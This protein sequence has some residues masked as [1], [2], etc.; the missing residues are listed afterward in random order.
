MRSVERLVEKKRVTAVTTD[1]ATF[2][3]RRDTCEEACNHNIVD[4]TGH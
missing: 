2:L 4:V 1:K 3:A